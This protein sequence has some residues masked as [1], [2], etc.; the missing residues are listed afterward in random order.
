MARA[1]NLISSAAN[2]AVIVNEHDVTIVDNGTT[3]AATRALL[4]DLKTITDK[5]VRYQINTHYHYDH[6]DGN[7]IFGPDVEIIGH[8]TARRDILTRKEL[9]QDPYENFAQVRV[10]ARIATLKKQ[11]ASERDAAA[12]ATLEIQLRV[13]LELV[14]GLKEIRP[15]PPN[16]VFSKSLTLFRGQREIRLLFLGRGHTAGDIVVYLPREQVVATGDLLQSALPFMGDGY[17]DE[18]VTTIDEVKKL[19]F[20]VVLPGHGMPITDRAKIDAYQGYIR[21]LTAQVTTFRKQGL[22]PEQTA[23]RVD[24]TAYKAHFT[25][26]QGLGADVR[27]VRSI[28]E[29]LDG[30][31][32]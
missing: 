19:D 18:W 26:I 2:V 17:F 3:P 7:Q 4:Q 1:T 13:Q 30:R 22:T 31:R 32:R 10:P 25:A 20:N 9:E 15:T 6:T 8:E 29:W 27:A 21:D 11:I 16:T 28:Y 23:E 14:E 24:L 12:L 5:P